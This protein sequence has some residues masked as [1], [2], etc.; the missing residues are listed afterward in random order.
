LLA[1][2]DDIKQI[3][4]LNKSLKAYKKQLE[5]YQKTFTEEGTPIDASINLADVDGIDFT[6]AEELTK[7]AADVKAELAE[8]SAASESLDDVDFDEAIG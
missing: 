8:S 2:A 7:S 4:K 6:E 3:K 5:A 1:S